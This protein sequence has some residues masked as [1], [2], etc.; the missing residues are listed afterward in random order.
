MKLKLKNTP[1]QV[2]LIKAMGSSDQTVAREASEAFAAFLGPVIHK[3]LMTAG[4]ASTIYSDSEF[5]EDDSP[6]YPLDL[7]YGD[8]PGHVSVWSQSVAGGLATS[9]VEGMQEIK[10]ATY[11][12]DS[13]VSFLKRYARRAR[14]DVVSKAIE[15][16]AQEV[17]IKQERNAWAVILKALA[18]GVTGTTDT[19]G[20]LNVLDH[21]ARGSGS[22]T[23]M[24]ADMNKLMTLNKRMNESFSGHTPVA[25][26]STGITDM[27]ISPE[28]VEDIRAFAY[29]PV[30][31]A[32][33]ATTLGGKESWDQD[34]PDSVRESIWSSAG[35]ASLWGVNLVEMVELGQ[36]KK[37]NF[38][39][40]EQSKTSG[41]AANALTL[42]GSDK[43][44]DGFSGAGSAAVFNDTAEEILIGIDNSRG[45]FIRPVARQAD[46]GGSFSALPDDQWVTRSE[47]TGFYGWLEEGRICID[48][49]AIV[50]VIV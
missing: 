10:I 39:F 30:N 4:T 44:F 50:G 17:L 40:N 34:V 24:L 7:Y 3:V 37:Y 20:T 21:V 6:S 28:R 32:G 22:G 9:H 23:L 49:R 15:R 38:L 41:H 13:A 11:R 48:A 19:S 5:D 14:L 16:M 29:N 1:E 2:E 8:A 33:N 25:P 35:M 12:L 43:S 46:S 26:F 31:H 27:Y 36:N 45:S 42:D 47:K 18:E